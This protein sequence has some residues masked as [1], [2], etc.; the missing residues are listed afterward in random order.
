[1]ET[2]IQTIHFDADVKLIEFAK[3]KI[4]KL[5]TFHDRIVDVDVYL[6]FTAASSAIKEKAVEIKVNVPGKSLFAEERATTFEEA[7]DIAV[8]TMK[9]QLK[10]TKEKEKAV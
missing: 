5:E 10:R 1:M 6:K 7:I 2:R 9:R 4:G 3:K 8:E